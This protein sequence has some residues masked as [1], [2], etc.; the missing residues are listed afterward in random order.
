MN[1]RSVHRHGVAV[2]APLA[3]LLMAAAGPTAYGHSATAGPTAYSPSPAAGPTA[4]RPSPTANGHSPTAG[5]ALPS[6]S[7]VGTLHPD[8]A[9]SAV[10]VTFRTVP[11]VPGVRMVFAGTTLVTGADGTASYTGARTAERQSLRLL[12]TSV[13]TPDARYRFA[14]WAGQRDPDQAFRTRVD[15]LPLR[16]DYTITAGFTVQYPVT[17]SFA[18]QHGAPLDPSLV[19]A[20]RVRGSDN[21]TTDLSVSGTTW[22]N[23]VMPVFR[24][25]SLTPVPIGYT[26][27]SLVYD[28]AEIAD[29]GRQGF[30]PDTDGHVT[31]TGAFHDLTVTA[32]DALFGSAAGKQATVTGPNGKAQTVP[33]GPDHTAVL[34]H[35][36]RGRYSVEVK[37]PGGSTSPR[38]VQLSQAVTAD[39]TVISR[40]DVLVLTAVGLVLVGVPVAIRLR[41]RSRARRTAAGPAP[42][43]GARQEAMEPREPVTP[44]GAV[45]PGRSE[46]P[47]GAGEA[48]DPSPPGA[49]PR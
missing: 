29:A 42:G 33:L 23:G 40:A 43:A 1:R 13:N 27:R 11:A 3:A 6:P 7:S 47:G 37:A 10:T 5:P 48:H 35:L 44:D 21:R 4:Y 41:F 39:L 2:L 9:A 32:H 25:S 31:F 18:D 22:L 45:P 36:P 16:A 49:A 38:E 8:L 12:D 28:G 46:R 15:G 14:R 24:D 20:V 19:S 34:T 26:L 30:R 17:V